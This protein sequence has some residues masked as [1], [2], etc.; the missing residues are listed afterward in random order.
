[1]YSDN[2]CGSLFNHRSSCLLIL[3]GLRM[4]LL[5]EKGGSE[6]ERKTGGRK[7]VERPK[8]H[9]GKDTESEGRQEGYLI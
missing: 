1:M 9:V 5:E 4:E 3:E 7:D 2:L 6:E 8:R